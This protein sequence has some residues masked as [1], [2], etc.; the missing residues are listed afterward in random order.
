MKGYLRAELLRTLRDPM[1]IF[2]AVV[3]PIG[4]YLCFP[5]SLAESLIPRI[6]FPATS[7]SWS[8]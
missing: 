1:Y 6:L 2:L 8:P 7:K 3:V 4:F 5:D